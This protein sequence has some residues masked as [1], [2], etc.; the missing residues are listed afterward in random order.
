VSTLYKVN[1]KFFR[2][3]D[4]GW[5]QGRCVTKIGVAKDNTIAVHCSYP[6]VDDATFFLLPEELTAVKPCP[7]CGLDE[8]G[9]DGICSSCNFWL[10]KYEMVLED[11]LRFFV[12]EGNAYWIGEPPPARQEGFGGR[13]F[14]ITRL[15][16][17]T[18][19][20]NLW[21]N[22]VIPDYWRPFLKD[23]AEL[24]EG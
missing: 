23:N 13:K 14:S 15:G 7:L 8:A 20:T 24:K 3:I 17:T 10:S 5:L 21:H 11:D 22:G 16:W 1:L 4:Y 2:N 6:I 12:A 19:T 9:E 18:V